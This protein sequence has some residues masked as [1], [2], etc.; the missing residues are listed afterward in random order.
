MP[1]DLVVILLLP[2]WYIFNIQNLGSREK[3]KEKFQITSNS[4]YL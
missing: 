3:Y 1:I 4:H 2:K